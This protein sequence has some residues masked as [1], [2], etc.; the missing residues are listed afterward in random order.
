VYAKYVSIY[1]FENN[2]VSLIIFFMGA[3][4]SAWH[5]ISEGNYHGTFA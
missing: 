1:L 4:L 3:V 2:S 5:C